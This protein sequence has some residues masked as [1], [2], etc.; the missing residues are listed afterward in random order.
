M[1]RTISSPQAS[2]VDLRDAGASGPAHDEPDVR[3]QGEVGLPDRGRTLTRYGYHPPGLQRVTRRLGPFHA[4]PVRDRR[5]SEKHLD[6]NVRAA[7][8]RARSQFHLAG[9]ENLH[10]KAREQD[11]GERVKCDGDSQRPPEHSPV[12][13]PHHLSTRAHGTPR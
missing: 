13:P 3:P 12:A 2:P 6:R 8:A 1:T 10:A 4:R 11:E 7:S 5:C 9:L